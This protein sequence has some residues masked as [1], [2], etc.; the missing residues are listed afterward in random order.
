MQIPGLKIVVAH[1]EEAVREQIVQA[2]D[3]RHQLRAQ[4]GS[5]AG[6]E[7][8]LQGDRPDLVVAGVTFPDGDGLNSIIALGIERPIPSVIVTAE[9]SLS[10]VERAMLDHVM[11]YLIEPVKK[12]ELEAAVVVAW[13]RYQQLQ[14]LTDQV[15]DLSEALE[16]RKI[17]ERAKGKLMCEE[18]IS[19]EEAFGRLRRQAQDT[20]TRM[21]DIAKD[22]LEAKTDRQ[23]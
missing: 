20:R 8:A 22:I 7:E 15:R 12:E 18:G 1:A 17:I 5:V 23:V 6:L 3:G 16:H 9:R 19:E 4:V 10:I 11:A 14:E 2:L 21:V 13:T